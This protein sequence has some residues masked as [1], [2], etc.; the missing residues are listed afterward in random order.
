MLTTSMVA[1]L[2]N[3]YESW[4]ENS[5]IG[6]VLMKA[7]TDLCVH[8]RLFD[9]EHFLRFNCYISSASGRAFCSGADVVALNHFSNEA[10]F[11]I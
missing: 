2:N 11:S 9:V 5:D 4:Q 8:S 6:I 10:N 1:P 7:W 3:L